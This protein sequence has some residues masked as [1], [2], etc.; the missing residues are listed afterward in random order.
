MQY[1]F[2][3][4]INKILTEDVIDLLTIIS[5]KVSNVTNDRLEFPVNLLSLLYCT[6]SAKFPAKVSNKFATSFFVFISKGSHSLKK[7]EKA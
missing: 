3:A 5:H 4:S 7:N 2:E 6:I 1:V